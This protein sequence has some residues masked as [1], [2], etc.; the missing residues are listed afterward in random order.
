MPVP[1]CGTLSIGFSPNNESTVQAVP[2]YY[3]LA[4]PV[5]QI[6]QLFT[7]NIVDNRFAWQVA[8]PPGT[9]ILLSFVDSQGNAGGVGPLY[10]VIAGNNC[11]FYE[12][13]TNSAIQFECVQSVSGSSQRS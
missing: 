4:Y 1:T 9:Q 10:T 2:P 7:A 3:L 11:T 5:G 6:P 8:Y 13:G 12:G